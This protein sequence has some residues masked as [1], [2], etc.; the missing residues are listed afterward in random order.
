MNYSG[1]SIFVKDGQFILTKGS[2]LRRPLKSSEYWK[3][4]NFFTR[5]NQVIDDYVED[6]K[7]T[8]NFK[9]KLAT[10]GKSFV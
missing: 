10:T 7:V 9:F 2:E 5:Y 3:T 1:S 4:G 6:G 8:V